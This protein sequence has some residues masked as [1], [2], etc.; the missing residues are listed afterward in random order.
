MGVDV[1]QGVGSGECAASMSPSAT[2]AT[3][4]EHGTELCV[5]V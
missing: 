2:P 5:G 1:K 4:S 3:E